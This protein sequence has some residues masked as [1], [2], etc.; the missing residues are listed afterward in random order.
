[1]LFQVFSLALS[2][3]A[4]QNARC[5]CR[6]KRLNKLN[7]T[8][9]RMPVMSCVLKRAVQKWLFRHKQTTGPSTV[10]RLRDYK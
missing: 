10:K 3:G 5:A 9:M 2:E 7:A 4:G 8:A 6:L 1:L